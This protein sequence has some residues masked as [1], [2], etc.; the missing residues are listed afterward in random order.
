VPAIPRANRENHHRR[1]GVASISP[2]SGNSINCGDNTRATR[3]TGRAWIYG[4]HQLGR[5]PSDPFQE[6][7]TL[8][9]T[10]GTGIEQ[11]IPES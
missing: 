11:V 5:D 9:D 1:S 6:G 10:W 4:L 2:V 3:I 8:A 7:F